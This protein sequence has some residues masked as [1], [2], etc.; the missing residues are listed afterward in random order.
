MNLSE[1]SD[2][3]SQQQ[4]AASKLIWGSDYVSPLS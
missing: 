1:A 2:Y 4:S 3:R